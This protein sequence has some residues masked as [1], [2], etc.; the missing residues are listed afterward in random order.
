MSRYL[1]PA[2][3]QSALHRGQAVEQF[4]GGFVHDGDPAIRWIAIAPRDGEIVLSLHETYDEGGEDFTDV[5]AFASIGDPDEA[6]EPAAEH[7]FATIDEAL[8]AAVERYGADL[9]RF[10]NAGLVEDEYGDYRARR[11][12]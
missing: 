2:F 8:A 9:A 6:Y 3:I 4:L 10:V 7:R 11:P 12:R 1:I 5:Y